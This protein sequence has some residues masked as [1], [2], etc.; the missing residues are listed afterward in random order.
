MKELGIS[1][2][3]R[4]MRDL[5]PAPTLGT[6]PAMRE[7][8]ERKGG[9]FI[10][11]INEFT[12]SGEVGAVVDRRGIL[13]PQRGGKGKGREET[14]HR[15]GLA[16]GTTSPRV[17]D[18]KAIQSPACLGINATAVKD[19]ATIILRQILNEHKL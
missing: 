12:C 9:K 4:G 16:V 8:R 11:I 3:A 18:G 6:P 7:R 15:A 13:L 10:N 1:A 5:M 19:S 2:A 17:H 14:N